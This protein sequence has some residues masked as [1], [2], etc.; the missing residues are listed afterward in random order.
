M[1]YILA[2]TLISK[3]SNWYEIDLADR[4]TDGSLFQQILHMPVSFLIHL[5]VDIIGVNYEIC[6]HIKPTVNVKVTL[7]LYYLD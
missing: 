6:Q 5:I 7:Y 4:K 3:S 1:I 2:S